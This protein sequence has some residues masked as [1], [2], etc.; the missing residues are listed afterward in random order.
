[1]TLKEW[2]DNFGDNLVEILEEKGMTQNDLVRDSGISAGSIN[3][4]I[5]KQSPPGIKAIINIAYALDMSVDELVD[6]G[7]RI[8]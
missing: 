3:A 5:H 4:Y 6:F 8:E 2:I 7:D 1:M